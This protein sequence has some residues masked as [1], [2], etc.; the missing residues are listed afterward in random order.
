MSEMVKLTA[1]EKTF[2]IEVMDRTQ[3]QGIDNKQIQ[4]DIMRKLL[5]SLKIPTP[6]A[7]K[8]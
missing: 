1:K 8:K 7:K 6:V 4:V 5:E 3:L 2:I